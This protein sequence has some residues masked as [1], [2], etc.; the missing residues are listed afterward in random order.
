MSHKQE[1]LALLL[2]RKLLQELCDEQKLP[3]I[4]AKVR[5]QAAAV[6]RHFPSHVTIEL[7]YAALK[8]APRNE[9]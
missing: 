9:L 8:K 6:L 1:Q 5:E 2:A 4:P 7:L 3:A